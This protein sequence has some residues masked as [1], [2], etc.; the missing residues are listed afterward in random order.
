MKIAIIAVAVGAVFAASAFASNP[1]TAAPKEIV[2]HAFT[3]RTTDG[4]SPEAALITDSAGNFYG[5]TT[6]GGGSMEAGTVFKIA[7]DGTE[8]KLYTFCQE[9]NCADGEYPS[10]GLVADQTGN[11][12]GTT[13][14]GGDSYC[15]GGGCGVVFKL[16]PDG[17]ETVV[18]SFTGGSDGGYPR[19]GLI[20]DSAGNLYGE[21]GQVVF[22]LTSDGT[23]TVL[24][25]FCGL[26]NCT[27][28]RSPVGGLITDGS[29]N[30][31]G[32]TLSGG[33]YDGG[34][35]FKVTPDGVETVL[36]SFCSDPPT[37]T[38]GENPA[39]GVIM[40]AKGKLYGTTSNG[41]VTNCYNGAGCGTVFKIGSKGKETLL[42]TF[43]GGADGG[44]PLAGLVMDKAGNLY[45][46]TAQG[47]TNTTCYFSCGGT[48]FKIAPDGTHTV[49]YDF[50]SRRK[51]RDGSDPQAALILKGKNANLYG[52][53]AEGG[54]GAGRSNPGGGTVF[55]IKQ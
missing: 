8:T 30:F 49:L 37:C 6:Y 55:E 29:G 18:H 53:T 12:Y 46:T 2:L 35:V 19:S 21:A 17:T 10:G 27:D 24:Y 15:G 48:V 23:E 26:Q 9:Q 42:H 14:Y 39:G 20:A 34:T 5:T 36:H 38:D 13:T 28:G 33:A 44:Q 3:T 25:T 22:K 43:T 32:T 54:G 41:A 11:F 52:T 51:C 31:Y 40:D 16:A 50:C 4:A 1:A 7:P 47:P 45:G